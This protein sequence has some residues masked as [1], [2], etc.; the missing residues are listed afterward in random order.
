MSTVNGSAARE[1]DNDA[2]IVPAVVSLDE[3]IKIEMSSLMS[4]NARAGRVGL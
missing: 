1:V 4:K 2:A 3:M